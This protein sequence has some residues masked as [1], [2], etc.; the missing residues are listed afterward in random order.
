V[1]SNEWHFCC[2]PATNATH[3]SEKASKNRVIIA[4]FF[5]GGRSIGPG[6]SL[7]KDLLFQEVKIRFTTRYWRYRY[8]YNNRTLSGKKHKGITTGIGSNTGN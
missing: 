3:S 1:Y 6:S 8:V 7:Q 4:P 5:C 2:A